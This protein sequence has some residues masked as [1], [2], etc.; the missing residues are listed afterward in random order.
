MRTDISRV[1]LILTVLSI[2]CGQKD[3]PSI[4]ATTG[5][6]AIP[7]SD[8]KRMVHSYSVPEPTRFE[9][10][11]VQ[12]AELTGVWYGVTAE[13][14][15]VIQFIGRQSR[16]PNKRGVVSGKW[17][18]HVDRGQIGSAIE[19]VDN[20]QS[21]TVDLE[22]GLVNNETEELFTA[23]LGR[24]QRGVDGGLYL[25]IDKNTSSDMYVPAKRIRLQR[26]NDAIEINRVNIEQM[27]AARET[28]QDA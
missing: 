22:V 26:A 28:L 17:I 27:Q 2:G 16:E 10:T 15:V 6:G 23:S 20:P 19:F 18:V 24:I 13:T 12:S 9:S 21:G 14:G 7:S 1:L 25:S 4:T 3:S 11:A 5:T 8:A